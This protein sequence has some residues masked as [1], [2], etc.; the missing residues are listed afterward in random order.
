M[1]IKSLINHFATYLLTQKRVAHNTYS[2]YCKDLEQFEEFLTEQKIELESLSY[3]TIKLFLSHLKN[4]NIGPRSLSR[5][6]STLKAF[7]SYANQNYNVQNFM[8]NIGFPK[9]EKKLPRHLVENEVIQL[10]QKAEEDAS[11]TGIRNKTMLHLL[12]ATGL[13]ISEL[14]NLKI[15]SINFETGMILVDGKGGKQRVVPLPQPTIKLLKSYIENTHEQLTPGRPPLDFLF[16]TVYKNLVKS[17]TR[18]AFWMI[19]RKLVKGTSLENNLSPH[20][21]RH[22]LAT[23]LLYKGVDLRSLQILLGHENLSTVQIYTH[24]EVKHL[25][26]IYDKK[27]PRS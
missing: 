23:H 9:L 14:V 21:L 25:R 16:P 7:F 4:H 15:P 12:Y 2:A 18:Q 1:N 24:L 27:H 8:V 3:K 22:T 26:K 19:L 10:M 11:P 5:K 17:I 6:I 13:R 20:K